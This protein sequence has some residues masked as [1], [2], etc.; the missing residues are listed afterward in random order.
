MKIAKSTAGD[1]LYQIAKTLVIFG[2]WLVM[3]LD[4]LE[5]KFL[6]LVHPK[7]WHNVETIAEAD[8]IR[9]LCPKCFTENSGPMGTHSVICWQPTVPA[10]VRPAPGRWQFLGNG[11]RD[12]S[13]VA[14]SSSVQ[15][16]GGCQAHFFV[17]NGAIR[18]A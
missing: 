1:R 14:G 7:E 5:P 9:F 10:E 12:L 8:G 15:L 3:R 4:E 11:Y 6:K 2:E 18:N 16:N 17:E 13:L